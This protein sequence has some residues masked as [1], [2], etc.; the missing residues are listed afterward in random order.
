MLYV[1]G[2]VLDGARLYVDLV[3]VNPPLV[4]WLN[5]PVVALARATGLSEITVYRAAVW[6]A[7]LLA[8]W[9]VRRTLL[10]IPELGPRRRDALLVGMLLVLVGFPGA[11]F[12]Q[13]EHLALIL[14]LPWLFLVGGRP[15]GGTPPAVEAAATGALGALGVAL[16]PHFLLLPIAVYAWSR[17]KAPVGGRPLPPDAAGM[18][19]V[20]VLYGVAA[21]AAAPDYFRF[22][23]ELGTV[24]WDYLRRPLSAI[25]TGDLRPLTIVWALCYWPLAR[26]LT[27]F[28]SLADVLGVATAALLG[29]VLLQ[30]KGLGYH[31]YPA[32]GTGLLLVLLGLLGGGTRLPAPAVRAAAQGAGLLVLMPVFAL[33]G[34]W[35]LA[36]AAGESRLG[37]VAA[38]SREIG[39]FLDT[40][41]PRG[42]VAIY[43]PWM[44]DSFPLVLDRGLAWGSRYA[45][46]WFLPAFHR[47]LPEGRDPV[48]CP[49][50]AAM[51]PLERQLIETVAADLRTRRP[52][53]V[54]V[55][56]P[57]PDG[58]LRVQLLACFS[59]VGAFRQ[60]FRSY[61]PL[62]D[63]E[64]FRVY[65]RG[66]E[67]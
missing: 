57:K 12:G 24:Y 30:H 48:G 34:G 55:R 10:R 43:S 62:L 9:L 2:R 7:A 47:V 25:L 28:G 54:F 11:F 42:P 19:A 21:V 59:Q 13:R 37:Q 1:A 66:S 15:E 49:A 41:P 53:L 23:A 64:H 17:L 4:V 35:A 14:A 36:R 27:R 63:L 67:T 56:K 29:A 40:H 50:E 39:A 31:Y 20:L 38:G 60:A 22:V 51:P 8:L 58:L 45:F 3:E 6:A 18:L 26:R 52:A 46:I 65:Q 61:H 5:L 32:L 33:L 44:E 16:K